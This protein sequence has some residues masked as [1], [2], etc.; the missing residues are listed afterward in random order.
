MGGG[1]IAMEITIKLRTFIG[2]GLLVFALGICAGAGGMYLWGPQKTVTVTKEKSADAIT[3]SMPITTKTDTVTQAV[4]VP[5]NL[6]GDVVQFRER[7]GKVIAII[8][9]KEYEIPSTTNSTNV[10]LG[11]NGQLEIQHQTTSQVDVT[12]LVN[13]ILAAQLN[14]ERAK[15]AKDIKHHGIGVGIGYH[16]E[17]YIPMEY[18]ADYSKNKA[19]SLEIHKELGTNFNINGGEIKHVWKF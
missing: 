10:E 15:W 13:Q 18:Q 12:P 14:E 1:K 8:N 16:D 9:D 5:V 7:S 6:P 11:T 2:V 4:V 19:I 3:E 17:W